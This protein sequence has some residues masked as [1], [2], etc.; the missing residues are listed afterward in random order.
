MTRRA[1][2]WARRIILDEL[3]K[4][5]EVQSRQT[6]DDREELAARVEDRTCRI[7][8]WAREAS[9][10]ISLSRPIIPD[11]LMVNEASVWGPQQHEAWSSGE[12]APTGDAEF[13]AHFV[14]LPTEPDRARFAEKAQDI[15]PAIRSALIRERQH[16]GL[17]DAEIGPVEV[18]LAVRSPGRARPALPARAR[19]AW[20]LGAALVGFNHLPSVQDLHACIARAVRLARALEAAL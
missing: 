11:G 16:G 3:R 4:T 12:A 15:S 8:L 2:A 17:R 9:I 19:L 20:A 14:V 7:T 5:L 13:D 1:L 6:F 18:V 10:A